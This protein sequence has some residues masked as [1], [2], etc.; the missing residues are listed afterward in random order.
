MLR[1]AVCG[2]TRKYEYID[3]SARSI[4]HRIGRMVV[5]FGVITLFR[6]TGG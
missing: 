5:L 6:G 3:E 2:A 1:I 4:I